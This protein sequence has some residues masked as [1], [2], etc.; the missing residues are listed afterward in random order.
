M[1]HQ[2]STPFNRR[3]FLRG[4]GACLALPTLESFRPISARAAGAAGAAASA[5]GTAGTTASGLPLRLG[6]VAFANGSNYERWLPRGEGRAYELNETFAPMAV[7]RNKF[8]VITSLAHDA[9]NNWGD[10]PGDHA[11]S[12]ASFLTGCHAWK[13]LGARLQLGISVDQIAA[14]QIGH[15]TRLDSL[16]LGVEGT[17]FYGVCDTGY[18]CA[19]QYNISWAS[20]T[21]P[22]APEPSP[23]VIF[24]RLFGSGSGSEREQSL[25]Q[26]LERRR[27][28]LDFV[29][30]DVRGLNRQL[31][32]NDQV[33][34]EQYLDGVRSLERQIEK[35]ERF[36]MPA[37][38]MD[39]PAGVPERHEEHVDM[40]YDLMA[41]AFQTDSTRVVSY[42]VAPEG[43]NRPFLELGIPEGH[44]FLTHHQGNQEKIQ[45]VAKIELWYMERFARFLRK[46]DSMTESDGTTVLD[47]SMIVYGGGIGDGNRHNHDELPVVLA[48]GGG[49]TLSPGRHVK[50]RESTPMTNLYVAMLDRMGVQAERVGDSTGRL[51][52][53]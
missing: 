26:R 52:E 10:G 19:Y 20:E 40:M 49:G 51:E 24:E 44:H 45:K 36:E 22:L 27:S 2:R 31:G 17:R 16:Q 12:G 28:I 15:L 1:S 46:L 38:G 50:L 13:T 34:I 48:G 43:S 7:L 42:C 37:A 29:L 25:R 5:A 14:R 4:V 39:R 18:P 47:N 3:A 35:S 8:Q 11:R 53:I 32:R 33:K 30:E 6:F 9:A 21:L 23:R 41:L